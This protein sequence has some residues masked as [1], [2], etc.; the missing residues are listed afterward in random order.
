MGARAQTW[1]GELKY[2]GRTENRGT[3]IIRT[4]AVKASNKAVKIHARVENPNNEG[5]GC[6]GMCRDKFIYRF[7]IQKN[8]PGTN[9]FACVHTVPKEYLSEAKLPEVIMTMTELCNSDKNAPIRFA[10]T[11][12]NMRV[13]NVFSSTAA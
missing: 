3:V 1:S 7:E 10:L 13:F 12:K 8:V 9:T 6:M 4:E 5:G 11:D 2:A